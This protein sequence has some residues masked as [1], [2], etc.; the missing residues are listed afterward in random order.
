MSQSVIK[1][2][3]KVWSS[4]IK[5]SVIREMEFRTNFILGIIRQTLWLF[6]FIFIIETIFNN[7]QEL[8]GWAKPEALLIVAISR[9]I[10]GIM[11]TFF[12]PNIMRFPPT[13]RD[14][15]FDFHLLKPI[16]VQFYTAIKQFGLYNIGNVIAGIAL[17]IYII[18][19]LPKTPTTEEWMLFILLIA[20]GLTIFYS[21][22]ILIAS[23]VFFMERLEALW[24]FMSL[25]SEP[26]TVPFGVFPRAPRIAITYIIPIAF[27]VF[28]PAQ[29]LTNRLTTTNTILAVIFAGLFLFLANM[30]WKAGLKNYTSAS[31]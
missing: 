17:F 14:G 3:A 8:A 26:L 5:A 4:I 1:H 30:A 28:V 13:V 24:G 29:A 9:I 18:P 25:F 7:T 12:A 21:F 11:N 19:Q 20:C 16:N 23:L 31:S 10:E 27:I 2:Y 6:A 15:T 22:F